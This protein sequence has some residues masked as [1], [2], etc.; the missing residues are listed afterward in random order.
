MN[1]KLNVNE[2][3]N[4]WNTY[5]NNS[6]ANCFIRYFLNSVEDP[7]IRSVIEFALQVSNEIQEGVTH[8]LQNENFPI[9]FGFSDEDVNVNAPRL[10]SDLYA[11]LN[12]YIESQYGLINYNLS[13]VKVLHPDLRDFYSNAVSLTNQLYYKASQLS[14]DRGLYL[15]EIHI[16]APKKSEF[17]Q[18]QSF[19]TGWFGDRRS[20]NVLEADNLVYSLRGVISAKVKFMAFSHIAKTPDIIKLCVRGKELSHERIKLLQTMLTEANLPTL[21]TFETEI[22]DSTTSP[23]S[24]KLIMFHIMQIA[25][26]AVGRYGT[27]LSSIGRRDLP[28][29]FIKLISETATFIED[30]VNIMIEHQW[31]EQ[32]PLVH[33]KM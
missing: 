21:P 26:I 17:I 25:Q 11:L 24:D 5:M 15:P 3:S 27:A 31:L 1:P 6:S 7:E 30:G 2:I 14:I 10:F 32:P 8:F 20:L 28:L 13:L 4:L 16:P 19:I 29:H 12:Y 33:D 23:F 22:T 18:K 9:P